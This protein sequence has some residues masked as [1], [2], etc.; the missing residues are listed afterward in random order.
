MS[1]DVRRKEKQGN[2]NQNVGS[3]P[4]FLGAFVSLWGCDNVTHKDN[5]LKF[6]VFI[7]DTM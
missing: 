2:H 6:Q 4:P 1:E 7:E 5:D 3:L